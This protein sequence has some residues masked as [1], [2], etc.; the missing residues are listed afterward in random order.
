MPSPGVLDA[1]TPAEAQTKPCRVSA[2]TSGGRERTTSR[3]SRRITSTRRASPSSPASSTARADASTS[4]SRTTR[5]STFE[6]AF[7]ATTT[8]S[9]SS[10]PPAAPAAAWSRS[11]RSSPS[12]SSGS[13]SSG[14]D[15]DRAGRH[16]TTVDSADARETDAR[17]RLVALVDV[18]DHGR[19]AFQR[20]GGGERA[21]VDRAPG[22]DPPGELEDGRL[23]VRVVA[24]DERV[25]LGRRVSAEVAGGEGVQAGDD[26]PVDDVPG[27][28]RPRTSPRSSAGRRPVRTSARRRPRGQGSSRS[29]RGARQRSPPPPR[30][31]SRAST[32]SRGAARVGV[33]RTLDADRCGGR[34][35]PLG[36]ARADHDVVSRLGE[37][38]CERQAEAA[39]APDDRDPHATASSTISASRRAASRSV[40]SVSVTTSGDVGLGR[41]I[42]AVDHERVDQALVTPCHM[43]R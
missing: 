39:G 36:V 4:A 6:T 15:A 23:R 1:S 26:R 25:L 37:A 27:S 41:S 10:S 2:I 17:V 13:P 16:D 11:P 28:A 29:R 32:R 24:A 12:T 18:H 43:R 9:P 31:S 8:T 5:P 33:G 7:W 21:A 40:I 35:R 38:L 30:P 42:G 22:G 14:I 20:A 34:R 3:L 19:Q